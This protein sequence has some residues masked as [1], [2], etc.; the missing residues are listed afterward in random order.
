MLNKKLEGVIKIAAEKNFENRVKEYLKSVGI[1]PFGT[2]EDKMEVPIVGYYEKRFAN[3]YTK[4]G[5]PDMHI[6]IKGFAIEVELKQTKGKPSDLQL[7]NVDLIRKSG[8][9]AIILYPDQFEDFKDLIQYMI[10]IENP[11]P[12]F[13]QYQFDRG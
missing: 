12:T 11:V 3:A 5:L 6:G 1:Y 8:G 10:L 9:F 2:P 4:S 7:F 13:V